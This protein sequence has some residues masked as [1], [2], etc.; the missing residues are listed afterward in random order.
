MISRASAL[1]L[2]ASQELTIAIRSRWTQIFSATFAVLALAVAGSGYVLSGGTG[3]QDF[4][5]TTT[6]LAQLVVLVIPMM[7]LLVGTTSF[8]P[9]RGA[10]ELLFSQ[11]V[12]RATVVAGKLLG[13][14]EALTVAQAFGFGAAGLVIFSQ[15]GADGIGGFTLLFV[16][17]VVLTAI[18]LCI[19][20]VIGS[21]GRRR[22]RALAFAVVIWFVTVVL[23]D[24]AALGVASLLRSGS[25]S[26]LLILTTLLNPVDAV[27]TGALLAIQGTG[28]FGAASLA[29]LRW[30]HGP[31]G[32]GVAIVASLAAWIV[33]PAALAS[34]RVARSDI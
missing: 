6:S 9:E 13:L 11:P 32:A 3:V 10:A 19:S 16:S 20:A 14:L 21:G 7:A 17:S 30:T 5:R 29:L 15:S 25:A 28:A 12:A 26:R 23:L 27:R 24:V 34:W 18:F 4:A 22:T 31:V 8:S 33:V 1:R 2:C